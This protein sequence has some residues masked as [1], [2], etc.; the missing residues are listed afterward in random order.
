MFTVFPISVFLVTSCTEKTLGVFVEVKTELDHAVLGAMEVL[1]P[2][3]ITVI[4]QGSLNYLLLGES[5]NAKYANVRY[6]F[7]GF[8]RNNSALFGLVI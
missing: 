1:Y 4:C 8:L 3:K 7:K 2:L 5:N 6:F